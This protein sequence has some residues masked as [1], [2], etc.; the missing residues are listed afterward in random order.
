M[1]AL[2][3]G[4]GFAVVASIASHLGFDSI[5]IEAEQ[6]LIRQG[7][8]TVRDW[9]VPVELIRGNF[10]PPGAEQLAEDPMLPSLGHP[11]PSAYETLGLELDDFAVIYA[12]PWPG[13][14]SFHMAV[15]D[16][17]AATGALLLLF[18]GPNDIRLWRKQAYPTSRSSQ[19][20]ATRSRRSRTGRSP[21]R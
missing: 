11:L 6:D 18:C 4:C 20:R 9:Q 15:F 17:F 21:G 8:Q 7:K 3:W 5:G 10:L 12:Y 2:E 16:R 19:P 13:E 14:D 1:K